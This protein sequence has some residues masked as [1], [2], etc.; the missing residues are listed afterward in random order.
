MELLL[1]IINHHKSPQN[2][3]SQIQNVYQA[4]SKSNSVLLFVIRCL[5]RWV[6]LI[7]TSFIFPKAGGFCLGKVGTSG[8][9]R[10]WGKNGGGWIWCKYCP[11]MFVNGKMRPV[12]TIPG[13]GGRW[14]KGEWWL[15]WIQVWN[16]WYIVGACVNITGTPS[17][18]IKKYKM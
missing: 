13:I 2:W 18:T 14:D 6:C 7:Y 1:L 11:H 4:F 15:G 9:G 8:R 16:I 17:T 3:P 12:E 10:I 5:D